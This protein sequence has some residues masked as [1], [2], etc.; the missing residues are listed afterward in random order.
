MVLAFGCGKSSVRSYPPGAGRAVEAS[1]PATRPPGD[2][3]PNTGGTC[4][5]DGDCTAGKNGR[6]QIG[7]ARVRVN[8]CTFDACFHDADCTG[9]PCECSAQ[10]NRCLAGNC[11]TDGDCGKGGSCG[12]SNAMSCGG[13]DAS[14]FSR[15]PDDTCSGYDD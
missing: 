1:C 5:T 2:A 10:G 3:D 14:Y 9:G 6:C 13:G 11:R 7:G 15:T 4:K 8:A 12:R